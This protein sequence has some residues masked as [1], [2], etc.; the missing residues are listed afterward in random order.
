MTAKFLTIGHKLS[1]RRLYP[2]AK[3]TVYNAFSGGCVAM[4]D[5][6]PV[7]QNGSQNPFD[8]LQTQ[9]REGKHQQSWRASALACLLLSPRAASL[10]QQVAELTRASGI[11]LL[12]ILS[13][14]VLPGMVQH[15]VWHQAA[16]LR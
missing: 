11:M 5:S 16:K 8:R 15:G 4:M 3:L 14:Q 10:Q 9:W 1:D 6:P 2:Y 13:W 12:K 7:R